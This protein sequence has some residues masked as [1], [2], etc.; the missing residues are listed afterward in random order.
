MN[1][2]GLIM[3]YVLYLT[4]IQY[5][6]TVYAVEYIYEY[7]LILCTDVLYTRKHGAGGL[8]NWIGQSRLQYVNLIVLHQPSTNADLSHDF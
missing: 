4:N 2:L 1:Q 3:T 8:F 6:G 5:T 7:T